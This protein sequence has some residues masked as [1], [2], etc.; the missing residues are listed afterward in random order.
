[1]A[2]IKKVL[3]ESSDD[4]LSV[5]I[6]GTSL[7]ASRSPDGL[8]ISATEV[9]GEEQSDVWLGD[10]PEFHDRLKRFLHELEKWVQ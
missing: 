7:T 1:M 2:D 10:W 6:G 5:Q 8:S 3:I 9:D 4:Y